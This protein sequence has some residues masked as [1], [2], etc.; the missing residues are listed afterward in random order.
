MGV[1]LLPFIDR[2]RLVKAMKRADRNGEALTQHEK[3]MNT[4]GEVYVFFEQE[5]R[6]Q[7][8]LQ[9]ALAQIKKAALAKGS[10][11]NVELFSTF[12]RHDNLSGTVKAGSDLAQM[13]KALNA[14][15][16][17]L[18]LENNIEEN[19]VFKLVFEH[20]GYEK[21]HSK[22]LDGLIEVRREVEDFEIYH[23]NRRFFNGERAIKTCEEVLGFE[24]TMSA[25]YK[26]SPYSSNRGIYQQ[27]GQTTSTY[28]Y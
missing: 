27:A 15:Y 21:H 6:S 8:A 7:S 14:P 13:G 25:V 28:G 19:K 3:A 24:T 2:E 12:K 9:Q 1:T 22:V 10:G 16:K 23:I 26:P 4:F 11:P 20:S 17:N 5:E 18:N